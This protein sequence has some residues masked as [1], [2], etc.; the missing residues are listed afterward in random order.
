M[1]YILD[2]KNNPV[3]ST[4]LISCAWLE[5]NPDKHFVKQENIKKAFVSTVFLGLDHSWLDHSEPL[6]WE[7]MI[8]G[9]TKHDQYQKRYSSYEDALKGH[10]TAVK[11]LK[12]EKYG[13]VYNLWNWF[14]DR[15]PLWNK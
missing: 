7:T 1:W 5:K 3:K 12:K 13:M 10:E 8:F 6:L 2:E 9:N 11:L 15:V 4:V 14:F